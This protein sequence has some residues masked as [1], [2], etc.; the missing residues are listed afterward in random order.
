[1]LDGAEQVQSS[2]ER[3]DTESKHQALWGNHC[4]A[5][6]AI[7]A[8]LQLEARGNKK[9]ADMRA[10]GFGGEGCKR[11]AEEEEVSEEGRA[12]TERVPNSKKKAALLV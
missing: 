9:L 12:G 2:R 11:G 8:I 3:R 1:M 7:E 5:E 4:E 10:R 6:E